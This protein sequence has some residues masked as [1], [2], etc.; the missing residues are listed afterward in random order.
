VAY[1]ERG[2]E[3]PCYEIWEEKREGERWYIETVM[4]RECVVVDMV[5]AH[6]LPDGTGRK[7]NILYCDAV[8]EGGSR[9]YELRYYTVGEKRIEKEVYELDTDGPFWFSVFDRLEAHVKQC[10]VRKTIEAIIETINKYSERK[11]TL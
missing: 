7:I 2:V 5:V 8:P 9:V 10:G 3:W 11:V 6:L 4:A 1:G